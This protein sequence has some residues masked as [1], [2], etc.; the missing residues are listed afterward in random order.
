MTNKE[1][2][3]TLRKEKSYLQ[4]NFGLVSIGLF[5]SYAKG[6]ETPDSDI[7]V[8]VEL[9]EPRFDFLA[10]LQIHLERKLGKPVEVIRKRMGLSERF[11]RRIERSI[12]YV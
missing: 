2:L 11:L 6:K 7:D 4:E 1:I 10:G 12:H 8:L 9:N 3:E 5:G